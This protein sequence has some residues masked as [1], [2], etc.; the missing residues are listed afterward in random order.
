MASVSSND[1]ACCLVQPLYK[2]CADFAA[3]VEGLS[4]VIRAVHCTN[5][6]HDQGSR[7]ANGPDRARAPRLGAAVRRGRTDAHGRWLPRLRRGGA[8]RLRSM[9]R[10]IDDGWSPSAAAAAII[11]G[12]DPPAGIADRSDDRGTSRSA[13]RAARR[14]RRGPR[15]PADRG[16][17]GRDVRR[18]DLRASDGRP[19]DPVAPCPWRRLGGGPRARRGRARG[20]QRGSSSSRGLIPGIRARTRP[21]PTG[22]RRDAAG[23]APRAGRAHLR[24]GAASGR[25]PGG[26]PRGG[27]SAGRLDRGRR[28]DRRAGRRDRRRHA[29]RCDRGD[30]GRGR[31]ARGPA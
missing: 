21:A 23:G 15:Q 2:V 31:A 17:P 1:L 18:R 20:E 24:D 27:S 28:T 3:C 6:V 10:L 11:A 30:V 5:H 25:A 4:S 26:L 14:C 16:G 29:C 13:R 19:R 7:G 9:R 8:R 12:T 22:A